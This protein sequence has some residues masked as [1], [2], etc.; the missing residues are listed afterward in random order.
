VRNEC[1]LERVRAYQFKRGGDE[2]ETVRDEE[3]RWK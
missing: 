1:G 3:D 2:D